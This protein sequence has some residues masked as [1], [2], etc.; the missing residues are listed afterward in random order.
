MTYATIDRRAQRRVAA[1]VPAPAGSAG[2]R[3]S[4]K[5]QRC[6]TSI[7][8]PPWPRPSSRTARSP[9]AYHKIRFARPDGGFVEIDTTRP[10][11]IPACVALVAHPDDERYK[12]L[13]GTHVV[14]PLFGVRVPVKAAP[15]GRPRE[16]H[17][18]RHDLHV[19]R[20]DRRRVVA[21]AGAAR[22]GGHRAERHAQARVVGQ[23]GLGVR[24]RRAG[25]AA[26]RRARG[27]VGAPR[28]GRSSS[29]SCARRA[30]CSATRGRSRTR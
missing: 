4:W 30:T 17:R 14:T 29:N 12:P 7:S 20:R 19:R 16:G 15:A 26:L 2:S 5:R 25:P 11:L 9:G 13:F 8:G 22:P 18:R 3:T 28:R 24:G 1:G 27:A 6:G 10:E 23:R 21:R